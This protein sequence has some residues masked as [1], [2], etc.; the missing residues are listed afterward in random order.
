MCLVHRFSTDVMN[1]IS[2][3]TDQEPK[4]SWL[5]KMLLAMPDGVTSPQTAQAVTATA[6]SQ[7]QRQLATKR[8][9]Q[10]QPADW[11]LAGNPTG[12]QDLEFLYAEQGEAFLG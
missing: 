3:I 11:V 9:D 7:P 12:E 4:Q 8:I 5:R 6:A 1:P 10:M 2:M